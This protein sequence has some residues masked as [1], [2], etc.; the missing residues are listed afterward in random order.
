[1]GID[2]L[3]RCPYINDMGKAKK[4]NFHTCANSS[5]GLGSLPLTLSR[6]EALAKIMTG[7]KAGDYSDEI[8]DLIGL[9]GI[10]AEELAE[11]GAKYEELIALRSC[12]L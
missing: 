3:Y 1:M 9:F 7:I 2:I 8:K 4:R 5:V 11:E 6:Q 12:F 10:T